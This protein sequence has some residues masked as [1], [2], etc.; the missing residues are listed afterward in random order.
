MRLK[1]ENCGVSNKESWFLTIKK[2]Y[3]DF[4][5]S[6]ITIIFSKSQIDLKNLTICQIIICQIVSEALC[7]EINQSRIYILE[8][9]FF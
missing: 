1:P 9:M 2:K 6:N 7:I 5:V 8:L 4:R 3:V